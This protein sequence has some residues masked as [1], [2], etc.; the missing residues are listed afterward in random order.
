MS[1]AVWHRKITGF[2]SLSGRGGL[3]TNYRDEITGLETM[4]GVDLN[5]WRVA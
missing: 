4:P 1:F 2:F 5:A 3:Y